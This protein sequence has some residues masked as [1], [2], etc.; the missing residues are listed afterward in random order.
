[1]KIKFQQ[2]TFSG[3]GFYALANIFDDARFIDGVSELK[4][5]QTISDLNKRIASID[6]D[7]FL[8]AY[9]LSNEALTKTGPFL[10]ESKLFEVKFNDTEEG[11]E[12]KETACRA[13]LLSIKGAI[14]FHC[15]LA[16]LNFKDD[17]FYIYDSLKKQ[18]MICT[19]DELIENY[20]IIEVDLFKRWSVSDANPNDALIFFK[21]ALP[22][23]FFEHE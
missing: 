8:E 21:R 3:C 23:L 19:P 12:T 18:R 4:N 11:R 10:K 20:K 16:I 13:F 15:I 22:H 14:R 9:F 17:K 7:F 2:S 1:M 5:G 6:A